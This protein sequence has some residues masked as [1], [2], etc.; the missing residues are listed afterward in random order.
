MGQFFSRGL[1]LL[2]AIKL[3]GDYV[4]LIRKT[5]YRTLQ[6]GKCTSQRVVGYSSQLA[7]R[8]SPVA[9]IT[10]GQSTNRVS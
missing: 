8:N 7:R 1:C 2:G 10:C 3:F 4:Q 5:G 9:R 6:L